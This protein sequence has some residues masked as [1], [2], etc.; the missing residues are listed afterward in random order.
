MASGYLDGEFERMGANWVFV[1]RSESPHH[2]VKIKKLDDAPSIVTR[3]VSPPASSGKHHLP[4]P[5]EVH[6][7]FV[8]LSLIS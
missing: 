5:H 7:S 1:A 4:R 3:S 6:L 2:I 8:T